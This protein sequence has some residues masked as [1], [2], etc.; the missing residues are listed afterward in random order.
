MSTVVAVKK[1]SEICIASESLTTFGSTKVQHQ[2][3][4]NPEKIL[5]WGDSYIGTTG[6][7]TLQMMLSDI[8]KKEKKK[9]DFSNIPAIYDYF[10][11]LHVKLKNKY[12]LKPEEDEEDPVESSQIELVIVN[13]HGIFS[14]HSLRE[15]YQFE[16]F[17]A[18][19]SGTRFALGAMH[20]VYDL[21]GYSAE[22]IAVAGVQAGITFDDGS[23]GEIV[24][25][26]IS[27]K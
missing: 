12:F 18:Y 20:A 3:I 14:V 9:P 27:L 2:F 6:M 23:G 22:Q 13:K 26:V 11:R 24:T 1:G 25:K 17:W 10:N 15:V 5:K 21:K 8:I 19:G 7:V 4:S 16:K